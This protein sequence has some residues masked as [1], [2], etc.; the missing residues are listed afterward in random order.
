M[1]TAVLGALNVHNAAQMAPHWGQDLAFFHQLVHSAASGGPW[2]SPLIME[3]QG[4]LEMVH[5]H[6]QDPWS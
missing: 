1:A 5:I 2:A 4:F 3:P 6:F